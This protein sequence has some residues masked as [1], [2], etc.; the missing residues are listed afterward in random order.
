VPQFLLNLFG[1]VLHAD[2][3]QLAD[4][5]DDFAGWPFM[6]SFDSHSSTLQKGVHEIPP[7]IDI[8]NFKRAILVTARAARSVS[9]AR[10]L[11]A[12]AAG[13]LLERRR[14]LVSMNF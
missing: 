8:T 1:F 4:E 6:I 10:I 2:P 11:Y 13:Q 5:L 12:L 3:P 9:C 7:C 14:A